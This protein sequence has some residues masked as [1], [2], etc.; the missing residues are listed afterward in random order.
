MAIKANEFLLDARIIHSIETLGESNPV[1]TEANVLELF[2]KHP[3]EVGETYFEHLGM[4]LSFAGRMLIATL[5]CAT[6]AFLPFM[7]EKTGSKMIA[8][9]YQRTGPGR[10]K[11]VSG[12]MED[13]GADCY[14]I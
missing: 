6:H 11:K 13:C 7:F 9:L 10:V 5:V 3:N 1:T 8:E 14:S 4:A 12:D 2:N